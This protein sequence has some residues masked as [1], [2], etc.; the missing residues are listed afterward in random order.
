VSLLPSLFNPGGDLIP[1][2][3]QSSVVRS[4]AL[5]AKEWADTAMMWYGYELGP[6]SEYV[7]EMKDIINS[8][9]TQRAWGTRARQSV[10]G[11]LK[12]T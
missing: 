11:P 12:K 10:G 2:V 4:S 9:Q 3:L 7:Q 6:D 1:I 8:P 5:A